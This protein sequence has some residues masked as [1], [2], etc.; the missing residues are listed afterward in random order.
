MSQKSIRTIT[1]GSLA[2][3]A[4]LFIAMTVLAVILFWRHR[5]NISNLLSGKEGRISFGKK[6]DS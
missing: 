2:L 5:E 4:V 3:L 6:D 1:G